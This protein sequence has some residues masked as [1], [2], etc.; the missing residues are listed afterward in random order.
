MRV[1]AGSWRGRRLVAPAGDVTRPVSDRVKESLFS[2]LGSHVVDAAVLDLFAGAG[3]FGIEALSRGAHA[4]VFV[5]KDAKALRS[6]DSNLSSLG[7]GAE[8]VRR[9]VEVY[10]KAVSGPF[11]LV[12]CD[13]PW[14]LDTPSL[15]AILEQLAPNLAPNAVLVITRR[16]SDSVPDPAGYQ[17]AD[18]RRIGDTKIVRYTKGANG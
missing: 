10:L 15:T 2:S 9:P 6:L 7:I 17:I 5:E 8:V 16:S 14:L 4:A 12:F 13:P 1:I 11:D 18:E 3:S